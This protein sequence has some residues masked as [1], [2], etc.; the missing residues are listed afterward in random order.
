MA[1]TFRRRRVPQ[2]ER[3]VLSDH[4]V[5]T[6]PGGGWWIERVPV[7]PRSTEGRRLLAR[8]HSDRPFQPGPTRAFLKPYHHSDR[9][10]CRR[11]LHRWV[12]RDDHDFLAP[13]PHRHGGQWDWF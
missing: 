1:H 13:A 11:A 9:Q 2:W 8:F 10:A 3:H 12:T 5:H 7:D 4:I 6:F